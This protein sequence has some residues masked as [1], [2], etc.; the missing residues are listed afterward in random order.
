MFSKKQ[1]EPKEVMSLGKIEINYADVRTETA[2]ISSIVTEELRISE[3]GNREAM[4]LL[5]ESDGE[6]TMAL[7][8]EAI[9]ETR[10]QY[11]ALS[12]TLA[13]LNTFL[14][15]S[16]E[17]METEELKISNVFKSGVGANKVV[18]GVGG[19]KS[20]AIHH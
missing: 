17:Q 15:N 3:F 10:V 16:T 1:H 9:R 5:N 18:Q 4:E 6:T 2:E 20:K 11:V 19:G 14:I 12:E 7:D 8:Q 13:N